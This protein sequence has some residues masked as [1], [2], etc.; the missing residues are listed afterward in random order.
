M[1]EEDIIGGASNCVGEITPA[2]ETCNGVDN[3]CDGTVDDNCDGTIDDYLKPVTK[4]DHRIGFPFRV[5]EKNLFAMLR[6]YGQEAE[7]YISGSFERS[8]EA[9]IRDAMAT[10]LRTTYQWEEEQ[11]QSWIDDLNIDAQSPPEG[12]DY[13]G[14]YILPNTPKQRKVLLTQLAEFGRR[15]REDYVEITK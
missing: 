1:G 4:F 14:S 7:V 13:C 11:I 15:L 9:A 5:N 12:V 3:D 8:D 2:I 10:E 6:G